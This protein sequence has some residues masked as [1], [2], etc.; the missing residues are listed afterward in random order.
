RTIDDYIVVDLKSSYKVSKDLH[1]YASL[2]NALNKVYVTSLRPFGDRPGIPRQV[3]V[4]MKYN[5]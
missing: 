3:Q 2:R 1:I 5:F 4:G